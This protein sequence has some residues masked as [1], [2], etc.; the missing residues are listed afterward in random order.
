MLIFYYS[1]SAYICYKLYKK[2]SS[3]NYIIL[4]NYSIIDLYD[5]TYDNYSNYNSEESNYVLSAFNQI[6]T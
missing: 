4:D 1:I 2:I 3:Y 5:N 6:S